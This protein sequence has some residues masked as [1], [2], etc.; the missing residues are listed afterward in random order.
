MDLSSDPSLPSTSLLSEKDNS[1]P[2]EMGSKGEKSRK[3]SGTAKECHV[4]SN[5]SERN[6]SWLK[7]KTDRSKRFGCWSDHQ[8]LISA[9]L[10]PTVLLVCI[11]LSSLSSIRSFRLESRLDMMELR[12]N[13]L[14]DINPDLLENF[15]QYKEVS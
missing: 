6:W 9:A 4:V 12:L 10:L 8:S 3:P 13:S 14:V 7:P 1:A 11:V 2:T 5:Q 15:L